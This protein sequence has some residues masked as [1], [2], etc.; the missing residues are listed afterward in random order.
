MKKIVP[1]F[2]SQNSCYQD[3]DSESEVKNK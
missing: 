2:V 3:L 1:E